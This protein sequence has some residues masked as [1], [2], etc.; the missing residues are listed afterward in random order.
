MKLGVESRLIPFFVSTALRVKESPD[1]S[2]PLTPS[3][4]EDLVEILDKVY[5]NHDFSLRALNLL[6]PG[7]VIHHGGSELEE[8]VFYG[9][10]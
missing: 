4:A 6:R 9:S 3:E 8:H 2:P 1:A 10:A 5:P 7:P